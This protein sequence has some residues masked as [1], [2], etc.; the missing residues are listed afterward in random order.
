VVAAA[1]DH[2]GERVVTA[3]EDK[4]AR[5][6]DARTGE[7][8]GK[9]L[10]HAGPI[11]AAAFDPTGERV[12]TASEDHTARIWRAPPTGRAFVD[13][14]RAILGPHAPEPLKLPPTAKPHEG[15]GRLM[16]I[17]AQTGWARIRSLFQT[18]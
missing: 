15:Y 6:W 5:I 14:V 18:N 1:F 3:S 2:T 13:E 4:N 16:A 12:V 7:P 8:I 11:A 9:P 17:G 10:Q